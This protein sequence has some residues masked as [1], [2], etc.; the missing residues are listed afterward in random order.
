MDAAELERKRACWGPLNDK[1]KGSV[2]W[3]WQ[4]VTA[5][6]GDWHKLE[7]SAREFDR[8]L[9]DVLEYRAW[10]VVPP[11]KPY[12]TLEAMCQAEFGA[13]YKQVVE[14]LDRA[15]AAVMR[16]HGVEPLA[17][18]GANQYTVESGGY[19]V[20]SSER[21]N[22][23]EYLTSKIARDRPDI[24]DRMKAGEFKSVRA[25]AIEAGIIKP[26][27][28]IALDDNLERLTDALYHKLGADKLRLLALLM[29]QR[30]DALEHDTMEEITND[31]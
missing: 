24:L 31:H 26:K 22:N 10:E 4:A 14:R 18:H 6:S 19:I 23:A 17:E 28:T 3:A 7:I 27:P 8:I 25:A 15:K 20:T 9:T 30:I 21:G 1:P 13:T 5:L 11:K 29:I 16:A 2:E 12:G